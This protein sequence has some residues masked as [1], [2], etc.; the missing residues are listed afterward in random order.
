VLVLGFKIGKKDGVGKSEKGG[1]NE[2]IINNFIPFASNHY[3]LIKNNS[4]M[5]EWNSLFAATAGASATL[6]GLLFV[7]V[8]INLSKILSMPALPERALVSI[9][10]LL[11]ILVLSVLI[12]VPGLSFTTLGTEVLV[13]SVIVWIIILAVDIRNRKALE[14]QYK[15]HF[16]LN[17]IL[18][19]IAVIAYIASAIAILITGEKGLYWVVSAII[20]SFFKAVL[21]AWVLL[22]EINR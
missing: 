20:F 18:D 10:L 14:E 6:T 11:T 1:M 16:L 2:T 8:S 7:G 21:D 13:A 9:I 4:S 22:V 5:N 15:K 17:V 3:S 12:L 19:Q